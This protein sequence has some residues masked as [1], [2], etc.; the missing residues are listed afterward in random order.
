MKSIL[1]IASLVSLSAFTPSA[2]ADAGGS[3]HFH[4]QKPA[5]EPVVVDCANQRRAALIK[6]GKLESS[7]QKVPLHKL[8]LVEGK[9]GKEWKVS[10]NNPD[11]S[12]PSRRTLYIFFSHPGNFIAANFTGR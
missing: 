6:A 3:C 8:E 2:M 1:V 4:G 7:W 9:K 12:D 10:F 11:A 5:T